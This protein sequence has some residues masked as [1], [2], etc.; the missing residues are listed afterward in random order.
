MSVEE[1]VIN[2]VSEHLAVAKEKLTRTTNFIEDIGA[3]S[4]DIVELIMELEEEFDIQIPDEE[5][6]KIKTVGEAVDYIERELNKK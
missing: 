6:Q 4:L 2:I 5:A 3:D 1:R